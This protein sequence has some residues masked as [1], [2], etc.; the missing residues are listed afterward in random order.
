LRPRRGLDPFKKE[1]DMR[2]FLAMI[3]VLGALNAHA[4]PA[5]EESIE[6]LLVV[7]KVELLES[8]LESLSAQVEESFRQGLQKVLKG[9]SPNPEQQRVLDTAPGK[10]VAM[11]REEMDWKKKM[12]PQY[13][14]L[15]RETFEQEEV[16][17]MLAFYTTPTGQA[18]INKMPVLMVRAR[19]FSRSL[20]QSFMSKAYTEI[21]SAMREIDSYNE[22]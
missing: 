16:D 4:A 7:M 17:E 2:K 15:Y 5:S 18:F 19:A 10:L 1:I 3:A 8:S 6:R 21:E 20:N 22:K 12:K 11:M 14:Q 13:V 9:K